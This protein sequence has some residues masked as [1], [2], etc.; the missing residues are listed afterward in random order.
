MTF[1]EDSKGSK[2]LA[3][4]ILCLLARVANPAGMVAILL[5]DRRVKQ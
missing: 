5:A 4:E 3:M 2:D 1:L